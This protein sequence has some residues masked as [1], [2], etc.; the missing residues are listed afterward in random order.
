MLHNYLRNETIISNNITD[1]IDEM[2]DNQLL[3]DQ[4]LTL[5]NNNCR[6][7]SNA[8]FMRQKYTNYFNTVG[9][10]PLQTDSV[11]REKY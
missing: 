10:V 4:L 7:G 1:E 5:T 2:P 11:A 6:T 8:I 9:S 3:T